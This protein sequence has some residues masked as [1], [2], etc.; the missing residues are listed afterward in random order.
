[1]SEG[2][3]RKILLTFARI[4]LSLCTVSCASYVRQSKYIDLFT[5]QL[6]LNWMTW[7]IFIGL[8]KSFQFITYFIIW[9]ENVFSF[10]DFIVYQTWQQINPKY[11]T[12]KKHKN[13]YQKNAHLCAQ[14]KK[15]K[16]KSKKIVV[17]CSFIWFNL[18]LESFPKRKPFI[19]NGLKKQTSEQINNNNNILS[20]T[21]Q[22]R[23]K[24]TSTQMIQQTTWQKFVAQMKKENINNS[25]C[26]WLTFTH[27]HPYTN[28]DT[29][30]LKCGDDDCGKAM[31][32]TFTHSL[33][34]SCSHS[35]RALCPAIETSTK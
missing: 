3:L 32:T 35:L 2:C 10:F 33:T 21:S 24:S 20:T 30:I 14:I 23:K 7:T 28:T 13:T 18:N 4:S 26:C 9:F 19:C 25:L 5:L 6:I 31:R 29:D 22:R 34:H 17:K 15:S 11:I 27:P 12:E 1:M 16:T 8:K